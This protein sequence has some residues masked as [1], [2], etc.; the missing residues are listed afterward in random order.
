MTSL[1]LIEVKELYKNKRIL[2]VIPARS[3]SKG[4]P[5]KNIRI[6][7][8]HPL[9]YYSI[10]NGLKSKYIDTTI[11]STDSVDVC[12][13]ARQMG[14]NVHDRK[15][16]LC[17]D[18]STLD[19][20]I[21]DVCCV[22]CGYDYIVTLQPTS[23]TLKV[24]SLDRAIERVVDSEI[25]TLISAIN[26]PHLAW[27]KTEDGGLIPLYEKRA[28]RQ[29]LPDY[30]IETGTFLICNV[31]NVKSGSRIHGKTEIFEISEDEAVDIDSFEDL[32]MAHEILSR[33]RVGIYVNGN[34]KRGLGHIYRILEI[35]DELY[36]KPDIYYDIHQTDD[37]L[38]GKT[39]HNLIPVD[40]IVDLFEKCRGCD[41]SIFINDILSTSIDY[42]I[43]LK[44][45]LSEKTKIINIEDDGEGAVEADAVINELFVQKNIR[46]AYC[47][48]QYFICRKQFLFYEPIEIKEKAKKMFVCFGGADPQNYADRILRIVSSDEYRE[49][50]FVVALGKAKDNI[51]ELMRYND[52]DNISVYYDVRNMAEL[53][54]SC[55]FAIASRGRTCYEL[56][57]LGIPTISISENEREMKHIFISDENGF[58]AIGEE[59]EDDIIIEYINM[60]FSMSK[61]ARERYQ[62]L[63]LGHNLRNGRENF[64]R[65][66]ENLTDII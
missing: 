49:F 32:K 59:P 48:E 37:K 11:V 9:V 45:V 19:D 12:T 5:N 15:K 24:D 25:D 23:P 62:K 56:A 18:E 65:I 38:F 60:Y 36:S 21:V 58:T 35:A 39:T 6:I 52:Y 13:I 20:V 63:L 26:K 2:A 64:K 28:N 57:I 7:A 17:D 34:N 46:N 66:L 47:G 31:N 41:Y 61:R 8:D 50:E 53:M 4:I 29:Y 43:G 1:N 10:N 51:E 54:S 40:G 42:M 33:K 3:G 14:V 22:Y 55:D 44:T 27:S 30:Y 16:E